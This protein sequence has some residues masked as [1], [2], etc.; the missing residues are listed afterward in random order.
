M[1]DLGKKLDDAQKENERLRLENED[2]KKNFNKFLERIIRGEKDAIEGLGNK[3]AKEVKDA[4]KLLA[5]PPPEE[6]EKLKAQIACA[7]QL[8]ECN[9]KTV[10]DL[11]KE[12]QKTLSLLT[13][14]PDLKHNLFEW[15]KDK[16]DLIQPLKDLERRVKELE[17]LNDE[18]KKDNEDL[19]K[20]L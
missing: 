16:R 19:R 4:E 9:K 18:L 17:I 7:E 2:M 1:I 20:K 3:D 5:N 6:V 13:P 12:S 8:N 11:R 15:E 10:E 14:E